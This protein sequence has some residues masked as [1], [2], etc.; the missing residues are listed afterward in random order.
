MAFA[1]RIAVR[2]SPRHKPSQ[3]AGSSDARAAALEAPTGHERRLAAALL[4]WFAAARRT[5]PWRET[6]DPYAVWIAE[7]MLQQTQVDTALPYYRRWMERFPSVAA[8]ADAPLES[9]LKAWEGLGY[10]SRARNLHRA[11]HALVESHGGRI[12]GGL[13]ALRALPGIGAYSAGAIASIAFNQPVPLVDGNVSRILS[14]L[15]ALDCDVR[16][17]QG[18]A[19]VWSAA[20]RLVSGALHSGGQPRD[21]NE[22]LMELGA[23]VCRPRAPQCLLCPWQADC[24][25]RQLGNPEAFPRR[26]VRKARPVRRGVMLLAQC[27]AQPSG[28]A[29]LVRRR[30]PRGVWGGLWEFPWVERQADEESAAALCAAL[31][32]EAGEPAAGEPATP[33]GHIS[34]GLTHFQ[35]ELDCLLLVLPG[36]RSTSAEPGHPLRWATSG[37][38]AALPL[39]RLSHKALAL[40]SRHRNGAPADASA[41]GWNLGKRL[42][43]G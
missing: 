20:E 7:I 43:T 23:L 38:L 26:P 6:Y 41:Q 19:L 33:L 9:V 39:A 5:L 2:R 24:R 3:P 36:A 12:P 29:W 1:K 21:C 11:A 14:R 10:Y 27:P 40:L 22:A 18:R 28:P 37:D 34:H 35:L 30:P 31:L 42:P 32:A 17:P 15:L 16:Q 8:V 13:D 4:A 25:A